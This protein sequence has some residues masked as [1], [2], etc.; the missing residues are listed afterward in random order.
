MA[1]YN[2]VSAK[3]K[4]EIKKAYEAGA[5]LIDL[6]LQYFVNYGTLRNIASE[7]G[8]E[9]GKTK[10]L[11]QR[12]IIEDDISKRVEL[13]KQII[14]KYR[15]LH[16]SHLA[17]LMELRETGQAPTVKSKEEALKHRIV[18]TSELYKLG[19]ELFSLQTPLE[20][21]EYA[22]AQVKYEKSKKGL[23]EDGDIDLD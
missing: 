8:W 20:E 7:E 16:G 9:K 12:A 5:D 11:M 17:Y 22:L 14:E 3:V 19:K 15:T 18:S 4:S 23:G 1:K 21:V 10:A 13:R 2:K 6:S